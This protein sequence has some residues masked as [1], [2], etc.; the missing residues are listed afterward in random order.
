MR[1]AV[2]GGSFN[3]PHVVHGQVASWLLSSKTVDEVW[4]IPVYR[5]AFEGVHSKR[6]AT[7]SDRMRW[8]EVM[9]AEI[10][11]RVKVS[12]VESTLP[13]PSFTIDTLEHL[14]EAYP[15]HSFRLVVGADVLDQI[16]SWRDWAGIQARFAPIIVGREGHRVPE[17]VPVFPNISSTQVRE[18]VQACTSV[19]GL[20]SPGV[21]AL[22][23]QGDPWA[24]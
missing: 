6:L 7:F 17:G 23:A 13:V 9:A 1:I 19:T 11:A 18:R 3:P 20:V 4:L 12:K 14:A 22:L 10:G 21:E 16:D 24:K 15:E 2:Y 5:H 8:C